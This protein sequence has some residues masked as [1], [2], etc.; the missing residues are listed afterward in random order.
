M[1]ENHNQNPLQNGPE[2]LKIDLDDLDLRAHSS[3]PDST[4]GQLPGM[5]PETH[6]NIEVQPVTY[7]EELIS[8]ALPTQS[9]RSITWSNKIPAQL[10]LVN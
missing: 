10:D 1:N 9:S 4:K 6:V 8:L 5:T 3:G 7:N 2:T